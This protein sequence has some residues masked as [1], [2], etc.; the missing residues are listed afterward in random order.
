MPMGIAEKWVRRC[1]GR[2]GKYRHSEYVHFSEFSWLIKPES[3]ILPMVVAVIVETRS[4]VSH[5]VPRL[6]SET[7]APR[8][9]DSISGAM[10]QCPT[11]RALQIQIRAIR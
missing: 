2:K 10:F 3:R 5:T 11:H 8:T 1:I 9:L 7:V 4:L 6:H